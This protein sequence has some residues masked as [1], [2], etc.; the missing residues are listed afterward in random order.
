MNPTEPC[1]K[2]D[3]HIAFTLR[4]GTQMVLN[5]SEHQ[6]RDQICS[7]IYNQLNPLFEDNSSVFIECNIIHG[8]N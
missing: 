8:G 3:F 1:V 5:Q 6:I 7:T 2:I 4:N